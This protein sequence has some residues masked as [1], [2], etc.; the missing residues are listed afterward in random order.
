ML[1]QTQERER[2]HIKKNEILRQQAS[3]RK[4]NFNIMRTL[5]IVLPERA[6]LHA[7]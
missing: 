7:I 2:F 4:Q 5:H 6:D 3:F 1:W